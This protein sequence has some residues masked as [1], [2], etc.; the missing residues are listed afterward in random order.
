MGVLLQEGVM[1]AGFIHKVSNGL[2]FFESTVFT[3]AAVQDQ[4]VVATLSEAP[5]CLAP[6]NVVRTSVYATSLV[7]YN[8]LFTT[9]ERR[10]IFVNREQKKRGIR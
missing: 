3:P 2:F 6:A 8:Y 10:I 5:T 9:H 7:D 4:M 1:S